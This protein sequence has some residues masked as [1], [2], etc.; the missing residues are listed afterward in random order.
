MQAQTSITVK[1]TT[2]LSLQGLNVNAQ[3]QVALKAQG[4]AQA[5][6]SASGQTTV[7]GA[8]VMIN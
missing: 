4:Q 2:D 3:A 5:E 6:L 1:A 7:R 8:L